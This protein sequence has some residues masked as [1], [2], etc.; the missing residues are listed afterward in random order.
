MAVFIVQITTARLH[1]C[2]QCDSL[3]HKITDTLSRNIL[4][5]KPRLIF[6]L[7][8]LN[9][10]CSMQVVAMALFMTDN[11]CVD[12]EAGVVLETV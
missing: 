2:I 11:V 6:Y 10:I 9:K 12:G 5:M 3:I 4:R 8:F 7:S 1:I